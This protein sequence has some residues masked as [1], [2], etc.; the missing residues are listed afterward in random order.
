MKIIEKG[1]ADDRM[2]RGDK[3]LIGNGCLGYRGTLEE[4]RKDDCV[5]LT[6]AGFYD[7]YKTTGAKPSICPIR[8]TQ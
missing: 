4:N 2:K 3:L 5:A 1:Y 6:T 8:F 7:R